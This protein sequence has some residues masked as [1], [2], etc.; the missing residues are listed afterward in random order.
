MTKKNMI[1]VEDKLRAL[2]DLQIVDSR[3]D[4]I[5][6]LRGELPLMIQDIEDDIAAYNKRIENAEEE[7]EK[8]NGSIEQKNLEIK[9]AAALKERYLKQQNDV[10][11][12]REFMALGKEIEYQDLIIQHCEKDIA[13]YKVKIA[14][15]NQLIDETKQK[16]A[17]K[18]ALL[19]EKKSELDG[20]LEETEREE[21][22][23]LELSEKIKDVLDDRLLNAYTRIRSKMRNGL[24]VVTVERGAAG[25]SFFA[26]P[27]QKQLE[28]R[29]R[30]KIIIDEHSGRILVD[31]ELAKEKKAKIDE[32]LAE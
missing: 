14:G 31:V 19:G 32:L 12:N 13:G 25:G 1:S 28:I 22:I 20:I 3:I 11:N 30:K 18:E 7:I 4:S 6:A 21:K 16:I 26:I 8:L 27:P 9:E 10:K 2:Y 23:L 17:D 29:E 24:A 15:F 5:H